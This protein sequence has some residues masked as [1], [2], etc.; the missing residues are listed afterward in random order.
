MFFAGETIDVKLCAKAHVV[1]AARKV[2]RNVEEV[3]LT[4]GAP[5]RMRWGEQHSRPSTTLFLSTFSKAVCK[6]SVVELPCSVVCKLIWCVEPRPL[7]SILSWSPV[8]ILNVWE[9]NLLFFLHSEH[10]QSNV[11]EET[12]EGEEPRPAD[13]ENKWVEGWA[14][15]HFSLFCLVCIRSLPLRNLKARSGWVLHPISHIFLP[16]VCSDSSVFCCVL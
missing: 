3:D 13:S 11:T 2:R 1:S 16:V 8:N 12:P 5:S 10:D 6:P 15:N 4:T 14:L 9:R 7:V